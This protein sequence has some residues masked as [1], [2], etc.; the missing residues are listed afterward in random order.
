MLQG[1]W[2]LIAKKNPT[3][4]GALRKSVDQCLNEK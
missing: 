4:L 3:T 1:I 2:M